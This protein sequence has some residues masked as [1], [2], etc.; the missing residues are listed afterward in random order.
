[1]I[2]LLIFACEMFAT[3]GTVF[4]AKTSSGIE[5]VVT[6]N[7]T[8]LMAPTLQD[9]TNVFTGAWAA[10]TGVAFYLKVLLGVMFLWAPTVFTGYLI[11]FWWFICF[12]IDCG[13]VASIVFIVRGVHSA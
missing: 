13:L 8:A 5:N 6:T 7:Q 3:G 4:G 1:M 9:S 10:I 2:Y 12:P 11:W